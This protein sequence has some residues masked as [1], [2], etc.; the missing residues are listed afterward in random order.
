[1]SSNDSENQRD[2]LDALTSILDEATLEITEKTTTTDLIRGTLI[3]E[4]TLPDEFF[5][6][7]HTNQRRRIE[8]L[9]PVYLHF[10]LPLDYPS[11]SAPSFQ[12]ECIWMT[13]T[14]IEILS[15]NLNNLWSENI[16]EPIIFLWYSSL[17]SQALDWLNQTTKLDLTENFPSTII[18]ASSTQLT[19]TQ[20]AATIHNNEREKKLIL[21][22]R[23]IVTCP[24]CVDEV[25]GSDCFS[26][27]TCSSTACK[28]CI[29]SYLETIIN[30]GQV[31]S[32][33][34]PVNSSCRVE[35]TPTQIASVVDKQTF[36]RYDRLLFQLSIDSMDDIVYCPRC[37]NPVII[38]KNSNNNLNNTLGEC[39]TCTF[40]F[41]TLCGK[42]Y[43]G[44]NPCQYSES[45]M[46][47]IYE[48][49]QNAGPEERAAMILKYGQKITHLID[50]MASL[51]IIRRT[52]RQCP[53]C[54]IYVDKIDGC[55]KMTCTKCHSYF[56]WSCGSG[57]SKTNPYS[58]FHTPTSKCFNKLFDGVPN[59]DGW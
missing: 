41:C 38:T 55:N 6:E 20:V 25:Y 53:N 26:C 18:D 3:I 37:Q 52:A 34:C 24:I 48:D 16:H 36:H 29:R 59:M 46:K 31:K 19:S 7:Y 30:E 56:C 22:S 33:T 44:V 35:L 32:I 2:E 50:E 27:Y 12:L 14:Q 57:L 39:A 9:P 49:Y 4:I 13:D 54:S 5:I 51:E 45:K 1:M 11:K 10:T 15:E 21:L 43:H 40:V 42:T 17:S 23:S 28:P 58:H 47:N 8:Y